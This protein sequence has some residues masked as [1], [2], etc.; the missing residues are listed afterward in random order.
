VGGQV[1][2]TQRLAAGRIDG[3]QAV[4]GGHPDLPAVVGD[5][6]HA[7]DAGIGAVLAHDVGG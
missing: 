6:A 1:D 3:A 4:A 2:R 5:S 7:V